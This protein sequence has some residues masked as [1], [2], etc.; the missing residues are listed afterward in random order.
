MYIYI[1]VHMLAHQSLN[2]ALLPCLSAVGVPQER[3]TCTNIHG[4]SVLMGRCDCILDKRMITA[5]I[6]CGLVEYKLE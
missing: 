1:H 4:E 3:V 6:L 2:S 5:C